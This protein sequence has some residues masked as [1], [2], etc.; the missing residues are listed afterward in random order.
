MAKLRYVGTSNWERTLVD[1]EGKYK[2]ADRIQPGTVVDGF[3]DEAVEKILS[4]PRFMRSF[5]EADGPEDTYGQNYGGN[6]YDVKGNA[7]PYP[8]LDM[9]STVQ[10]RRTITRTV[11]DNPEG[12]DL[13]APHDGP[14]SDNEENRLRQEAVA[15]GEKAYEKKVAEQQK[16]RTAS[17]S[18]SKS[19]SPSQGEVRSEH[20]QS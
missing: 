3:D 9:G 15:E 17:R 8:E 10:P 2:G 1:D 18:A 7:S 4:A 16:S 13:A 6:R 20:G 12:F 19:G 5:V 14:G 11:D